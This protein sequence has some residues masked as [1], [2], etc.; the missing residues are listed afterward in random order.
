MGP[1]KSIY[2]STRPGGACSG[3]GAGGMLC[4]NEEFQ[5]RNNMFGMVIVVEQSAGR[6]WKSEQLAQG[7][8][9]ILPGEVVFLLIPKMPTVFQKVP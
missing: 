5:C 1:Q 7:V 8:E 2:Y 6:V 3:R 9:E 4:A